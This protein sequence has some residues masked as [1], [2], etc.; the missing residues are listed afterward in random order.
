MFVGAAI[1][2][3]SSVAIAA[4]P[5]YCPQDEGG[6]PLPGHA[7]DKNALAEAFLDG[8][9]V[10][11]W[12]DTRA[13][14]SKDPLVAGLAPAEATIVLGPDACQGDPKC[15]SARN[16]LATA[17]TNLLSE[18]GNS[19]DVVFSHQPAGIADLFH[20]SAVVISCKAL[21]TSLAE[22][23]PQK[24]SPS[25]SPSLA[26]AWNNFRV[27]GKSS[28]LALPQNSP[29]YS[30]TS[31]GTISFADD[32]ENKKSSVKLV[33][34]V[35]YAIIFPS[36]NERG[37]TA[38]TWSA[39]P[40]AAIDVETSKVT[41]KPKSTSNDTAEIGAVFDSIFSSVG[42]NFSNTN[43]EL[44]AIPK[45]I[46]NND[47]H[48]RVLGLN[49]L[50]RPFLLGI[51]NETSSI[52]DSPF[53][54]GLIANLRWNNGHFTK[55]GIRSSD[56]SKDFSRVGGEFGLFV[57][58]DNGFPIPI[59]LSVSDI[60]MHALAGFPKHLSLLV[61]D[62]TIYLDDKKHFGLDL[63]YS[64]GRAEDLD[65]SQHKWSAGFAIKY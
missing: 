13:A 42:H 50:Y 47:D 53:Q 37:R 65:S 40:Y 61:G 63:S 59:E 45:F 9:K 29:G 46:W 12:V 1:F 10:P 30:G 49:L 41:G 38:V 62:F 7:V 25:K 55:T 64:R 36:F 31:K 26:F 57:A 18:I 16:S 3:S 35:G 54:G 17:Q 33:G 39:I 27:R 48:S 51:I 24:G 5:P 11:R 32:K 43:H 4:A 21:P 20:N 6:N 34:A 14:R 44:S 22:A 60:Y 15:K 28:E 23:P 58:S 52:G 56:Q 19:T 8:A 2:L